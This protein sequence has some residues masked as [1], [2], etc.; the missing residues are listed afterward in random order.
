MEEMYSINGTLTCSEYKAICK[1]N[2]VGIEFSTNFEN[3][4]CLNGRHE[5]IVN[6]MGIIR[7][8]EGNKDGN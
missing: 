6:V 4:L 5:N 8:E 7:H 2:N 1:D 3:V